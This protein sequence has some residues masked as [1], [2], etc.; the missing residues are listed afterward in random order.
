MNDHDRF[1]SRRRVL[2]TGAFAAT[3]PCPRHGRRLRPGSLAPTPACHDGDE[4][5]LPEIEGPYTSSQKSP[6]A[7]RDLRRTGIA[8]RPVELIRRGADARMPADSQRAGLDLWHADDG[9]AYDNKGF[10]LRG[11]IFTDAAGRYSF[12]TI[13][14]G[15]STPAAA[16]ATITS[17]SRRPTGRC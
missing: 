6:A 10:R 2:A 14:A 16:P 3:L 12:R 8:G 15:R 7:Q 4:P 17:K 11:H 9:G 1:L 13:P 5:T